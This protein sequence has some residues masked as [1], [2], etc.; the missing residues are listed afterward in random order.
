MIK[1]SLFTLSLLAATLLL[2]SKPAQ[3]IPPGG[4][5]LVVIAYFS[6]VA[7]TQLIGQ[8]W[9]GCNR[10]SGSWGV[11]TGLNTVYFTPC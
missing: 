3:A 5:V 7:K 8:A 4:N 2:D 10:P 6:D 11:T 1:R 9:T